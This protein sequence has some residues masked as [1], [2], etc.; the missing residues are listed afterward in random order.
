MKKIVKFKSSSKKER[1][2]SLTQFIESAHDFIPSN[3][4]FDYESNYWEGVGNFTVFG[5]NSRQRNEDQLLDSDILP[6]AKAYVVY[7]GLDES[8]TTRKFKAIRA[9]NDACLE[10]YGEV[11]ITKLCAA[12]F[13]KAV[14]IAQRSG[15]KGHAYQA[16]IGLV[17]LHELLTE[18]KIIKK[19]IW[20]NPCRKP[21]DNSTSEQ[22]DQRRQEKMP[23]ERALLA[24]AEIFSK[25]AQQ[26]SERDICVTSTIALLMSAPGR[27]SEPFYLTKDCL[28]KETMRADKAINLGMSQR[29]VELLIERSE[30]SNKSSHKALLDEQGNLLEGCTQESNRFIGDKKITLIGVRWYSGKGYEHATKWLPAV[31]Y[32]VVEEAISRLLTVSEDARSFAKL[33]EQDPHKFPRHLLCPKVSEDQLL[34]M[35]E[36]ALALGM[37]LSVYDN[38]RQQMR[39]SR[40]QLLRKNGI[41]RKDFTVTLRDLNKIVRSKLPDGF[42]LHSV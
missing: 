10:L 32:D 30:S 35:D 3:I 27:G 37:D 31:M 23:D 38:N 36:V 2:K 39:T 11:D 19:F 12:T 1:E 33:L 26:L 9:I 29:D 17:S 40:N 25:G 16:S 20:K 5:A 34:T 28:T 22:A 42:S 24:L 15:S 14:T 21:S 18:K 7:G 6:F 4:R 13:H 41:D 8:P